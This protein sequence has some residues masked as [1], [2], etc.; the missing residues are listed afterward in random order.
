MVETFGERLQRL[1]TARGM[2]RYAVSK[3][4][5]LSQPLLGQLERYQSGHKINAGTLQRL[6]R[7]YGV[8]MEELL[9]P[10]DD[11]DAQAA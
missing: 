8:T 2:S 4:T 11:D 10:L 6:A 3:A 7:F 9:G 1:R 5:G